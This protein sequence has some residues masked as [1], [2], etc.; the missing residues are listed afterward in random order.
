ME[1]VRESPGDARRFEI[2][3]IPSPG[4]ITASPPTGLAVVG[5][6]GAAAGGLPRRLVCATDDM[7]LALIPG[8]VVRLGDPAGG[9]AEEERPTVFV[10]SF[11]MD[12]HE[13]TVGQ[14]ERFLV[15]GNGSVDPPANQGA[16]DEHPAL[17]VPWRSALLYAKWAGRALPTEAEWERAARGDDDF[18][19]PWG[20]GQPVFGRTREAGQIDPVMSYRTDRSPF[21]VY[22]LA[23]NAAEWTGQ[24][25]A[26]DPLLGERP[27][28]AGLIRDPDRGL[29]GGGK[30]A[31]RG[32]GPGWTPGRRAAFDVGDDVRGVGF[33]CVW[34]PTVD[35][36]PGGDPLPGFGT[37]E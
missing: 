26:D 22:D 20:H 23:G 7:T 19:Y 24:S 13:V 18:R 16:P 36:K 10:S 33:R 6:A 37:G 28:A 2:A 4:G 27:D 30:R 12:R 25:W 1:V 31:V 14:F 17:G 32:V 15:D 35:G 9:E 3:G 34:R 11:Y 8:G 29:G 21:G 5:S